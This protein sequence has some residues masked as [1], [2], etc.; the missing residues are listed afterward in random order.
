MTCQPSPMLGWSRVLEL[1]EQF[2]VGELSEECRL[3]VS[4]LLVWCSSLAST[5]VVPARVPVSWLVVAFLLGIFAANVLQI[6]WPSVAH[7]WSDEEEPPATS[8]A[9]PQ[10]A[11]KRGRRC[12]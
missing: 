9:S 4:L 12:T 3:D 2:F 5:V 8:R 6:R 10:V 7:R 1:F 11:N